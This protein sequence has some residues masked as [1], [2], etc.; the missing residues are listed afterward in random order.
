MFEELEPN[1][2]ETVQWL[3]WL[4]PNGV[5]HIEL[6]P[7]DKQG[8][9][10]VFRFETG[11]REQ[12]KSFIKRENGSSARFNMHWVPDGAN[13]KNGKR[14][15][16]NLEQ[17]EFLHV[18]LDYKDYDGTLQE[19]RAKIETLLLDPA[20]RPPGV[21]EPSF[22]WETGGGFQALWKLADPVAVDVAEITNFALLSAFEG[23]AGTHDPGRLIRLP[24]TTNWLNKKKRG[25]GRQPSLGRVVL[26]QDMDQPP[27]LYDINEFLLADVS[28]KAKKPK[29]QKH[30]TAFSSAPIETYVFDGDPI[31]Q[32]PD[33]ENWRNAI[34]TGK[35]P[36]GKTFSSRSEHLF[37]CL[38]WMLSQG[39]SDAKA[40]AILSYPPKFGH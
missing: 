39:V 40:L 3:N 26:P 1:S 30:D 37:A 16:A 7:S 13:L 31:V 38:L 14:G 12:L 17:V 32:L 2:E 25:E 29:A 33:D 5:A 22:V 19:Q 27:K 15:K 28:S 23:G 35:E 6:L 36:P 9:P 10:Q 18:D 21:P 11:K 8:P 34:A 4:L 24:G 20:G